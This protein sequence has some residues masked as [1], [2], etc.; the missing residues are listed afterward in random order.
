MFFY[1][2]LCLFGWEG[3]C[4]CDCI[5]VFC[6]CFSD[7]CIFCMSVCTGVFN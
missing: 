4:V 3:L 5:V 7:V 2:F 6:N 1:L